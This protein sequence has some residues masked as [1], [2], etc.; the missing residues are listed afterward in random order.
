MTVGVGDGHG[1][2]PAELGVRVVA[3]AGHEL[4][5]VLVEAEEV[6]RRIVERDRLQR[7]DARADERD[8]RLR[9]RVVADRELLVG[10]DQHVR[11]LDLDQP[12]CLRERPLCRPVA[13][14]ENELDRL[15]GDRAVLEPVR[16]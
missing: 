4:R 8:R 12:A 9:A 5:L 6:R 11:A 16:G 3:E 14:A 7:E 1:R 2:T 10:R 13:A 15:A